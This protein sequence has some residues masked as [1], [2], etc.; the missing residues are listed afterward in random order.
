MQKHSLTGSAVARLVGVD[1]RAVRRWTGGGRH[2]PW[3]AW[4]L[5]RIL[6]GETTPEAVLRDLQPDGGSD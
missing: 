4:T 5:L 6:I 2:M 1:S 3:A